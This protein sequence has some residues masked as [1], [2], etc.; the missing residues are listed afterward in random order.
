MSAFLIL[1]LCAGLSSASVTINGTALDQIDDII[2]FTTGSHVDEKFSLLKFM[3][4]RGGAFSYYPV[5]GKADGSNITLTQGGVHNNGNVAHQA[6]KTNTGIYPVVGKQKTSDG[7]LVVLF[8][9]A[10]DDNKLFINSIK[11][12]GNNKD[13]SLTDESYF[14]KTIDEKANL[15]VNDSASGILPDGNNGHEI[16]AV[17]YF[18]ANSGKRPGFNQ[19]YDSYI[20][21]V[22]PEGQS[23]K[24]HRIGGMNGTFPSIRV[25]AGD[26]DNDGVS[27][28]LAVIRDGSGMDYYMQVFKVDSGLNVNEIYHA[29]IGRRNDDGDNIDGCDITA[30]DFNGDN[31]NEIAVVYANKIDYDGYPS[32]TIF[33]W[34]GSTFTQK[35]DNNED[36]N[37][38]VGSTYWTRSSYVPHFG[39]TA[40]AGD[41]NDD[42]QDELIFLTASYGSS[43]G[44]IVVSVWGADDNLQPKKYFYRRTSQKIA[45]YGGVGGTDMAECSYLPR[46]LSL[47][48][49]PTGEKLSSGGIAICER[50]MLFTPEISH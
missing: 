29:S 3:K 39:I 17:S 33:S 47:A 12:S 36:N 6:G 26:F 14:Y 10:Q 13:Y 28:E 32:I 49:V 5:Y 22:D 45:G 40:E 9:A 38:R 42:G 43:E 50:H 2:E 37:V 41:I 16:F 11:I 31:N 35:T 34:D 48:L 30:G 24:L 18:I 21:L 44:N 8:P 15:Y 20:A 27:N 46:S 19:T 23:F 1:T 7:K 25:T 4:D